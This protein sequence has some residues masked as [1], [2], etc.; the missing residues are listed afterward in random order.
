MEQKIPPN[1]KF[2]KLYVYIAANEEICLRMAS[3]TAIKT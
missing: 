1:K 3:M 2:C